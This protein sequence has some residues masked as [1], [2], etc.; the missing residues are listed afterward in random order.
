MTAE[1][2]VN[3]ACFSRTRFRLAFISRALKVALDVAHDRHARNLFY[4]MARRTDSTVGYASCGGV[5][6]CSQATQ[7][8]AV[9]VGKWSQATQCNGS[10]CLTRATQTAVA[11]K[12]SGSQT[13][14]VQL[15]MLAFL[16][17]DPGP[18]ARRV[19]DSLSPNPS[20]TSTGDWCMRPSHWSGRQ[21]STPAP[22]APSLVT[23]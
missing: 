2:S 20:Q 15:R 8:A 16:S 23:H 19:A 12:C 11:L 4:V 9:A 10:S 14:P 17:L 3:P 18:P 22:T 7:A 21:G 6:T 13:E 5:A 1:P